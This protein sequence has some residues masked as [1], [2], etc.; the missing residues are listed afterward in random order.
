MTAATV[1]RVLHGLFCFI[2][3]ACCSCNNF[4]LYCSC[5]PSFMDDNFSDLINGFK[6]IALLKLVD[7]M[8]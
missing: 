5:D 3:V 1:V 7:L 2:A 8:L 4:K 6:F